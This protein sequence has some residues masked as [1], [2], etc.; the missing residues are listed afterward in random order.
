MKTPDWFSTLKAEKVKTR[1]IGG[2]VARHLTSNQLFFVLKKKMRIG[3]CFSLP[4]A[5]AP[6]GSVTRGTGALGSN[7]LAGGK[8]PK[9]RKK[10]LKE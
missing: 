6:R 4:H 5:S 10:C 7:A 3:S 9:K 8:N 1:K 2:L